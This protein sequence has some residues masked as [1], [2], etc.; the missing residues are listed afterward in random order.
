MNKLN[1]APIS[2]AYAIPSQQIKNNQQEISKLQKIIESSNPKSTAKKETSTNDNIQSNNGSRINEKEDTEY[3][4]LKLMSDPKF[5]K[6]V[7]NYVIMKHPEWINGTVGT[8][9][10]GDTGGTGGTDP[11]PVPAENI[12]IPIQ[13]KENG[14][15]TNTGN[16]NVSENSTIPGN[17]TK[18]NFSSIQTK[19]TNTEINNYI[20]FFVFSMLLYFLFGSIYK[21]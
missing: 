9:G 13:V 21:W 3:I 7:K 5:D 8:V 17:T 6:I 10:T 16:S 20:I 1:F 19:R 4:F 18:S 14:N 15:S 11:E 2:D 12:N